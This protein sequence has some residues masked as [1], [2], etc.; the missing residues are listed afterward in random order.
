[1]VK[2]EIH[3]IFST[4]AEKPKTPNTQTPIV[5]DTREKQALV[6]SYL[7]QKNANISFEKLEIGDYLINDIAI[8]RK[9]FSDFQSSIFNKRL[10]EQ[11]KEIKKYPK[12]ILILEGFYYN[13][14]DSRIHENALR[15]MLLS[16]VLNFQVP[17]IFTETEEDTANYL[18][19]LAR[20]QEKVKIETSLRPIKTQKTFEETKQFIL[21]GFPGIGPSTSKNLIKEFKSLEN[22]FNATKEQLKIIGNF[23]E[24]K[25]DKFK[26]ILEK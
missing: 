19:V 7:R 25:I 10:L 22:I 13:Y 26:E 24:A 21:E 6:A 1:M 5:V 11:L 8:E 18:L 23:Q 12:Q 15:G 4:K 3:N 16:I 14:K 20:Q 17:I 9:T 2:K